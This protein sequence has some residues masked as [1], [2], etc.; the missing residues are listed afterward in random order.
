M[1]WLD[2]IAPEMNIA[3]E[4]MN[5]L[6]YFNK[7]LFDAARR[8]NF[9][10]SSLGEIGDTKNHIYL[11][12][13]PKVNGGNGLITSGFH[14][15]EIAGP[16]GVVRFLENT[17]LNIFD[18]INV[19]IIPLVNPMGFRMNM[20]HGGYGDDSNRGY[21]KTDDIQHIPQLSKEGEILRS[22]GA[23][24]KDLA[25]DGLICLHENPGYDFDY[26]IYG[27]E[28]SAEPGNFTN[29]FRDI[30]TKYFLPFGFGESPSKCDAVIDSI[31]FK[32]FDGGFQDWLFREGMTDR[33][34]VTETPGNQPLEKR[35]KCNV[36]MIEAFINWIRDNT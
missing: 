17:D 13:R 6:Y 14:G 5:N 16:W 23:I 1:K 2:F 32:R 28:K 25:K 26:F 18:N 22:H 12:K 15:N 11:L 20:R 34:V 35:L 9:S 4:V 36:E 24:Y 30:E 19:S 33:A 31:V 29:L 7:R 10:I 8:C 21:I 27:Y 3:Y